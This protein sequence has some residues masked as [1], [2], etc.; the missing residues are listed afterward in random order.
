MRPSRE[1]RSPKNFDSS[2]LLMIDQHLKLFE[3][4]S[5]HKVKYLLIGGALAIAYGIPRITKDVDIF[6]HPTSDN[7]SRILSALKEIGMGTAGLISPDELIKTEVTIFKDFLRLDVLTKVKGLEFDSAWKNRKTLFLDKIP[8]QA[9]SL[10]DL[11][12]SKKAVGRPQ[13]F[14]DIKI[15][16]MART[17]KSQNP[18]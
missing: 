17:S 15:L 2:N 1:L 16:E 6:V 3:S 5:R 4:L 12:A 14:E 8:I 11:I 7:A 10:E 9:L 18:D 13:D